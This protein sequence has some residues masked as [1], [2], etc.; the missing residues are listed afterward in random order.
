MTVKKTY[1]QRE[2]Q[3][4]ST[5]T[6]LA[7]AGCHTAI[8]RFEKCLVSDDGLYYHKRC[9]PADSPEVKGGVRSSATSDK[10]GEDG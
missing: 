5:S 1:P 8:A 7:C 2:Y 6:D 4:I 9:K 3:E 10:G